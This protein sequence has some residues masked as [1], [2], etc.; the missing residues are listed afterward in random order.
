MLAHDGHARSEGYM[1]ILFAWLVSP[2][3]GGHLGSK[4]GSTN[5]NH[6]VVRVNLHDGAPHVDWSTGRG[7]LVDKLLRTLVVVLLGGHC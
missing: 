6:I 1:R 3:L 5:L 7:L 2:E 4:E